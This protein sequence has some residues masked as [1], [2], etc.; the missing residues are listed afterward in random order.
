[1]AYWMITNRHVPSSGGLGNELSDELSYWIASK[2][3]LKN[4]RSWTRL[5]ETSR[6]SAAVQFESRL[7]AVAD[8]FPALA[9]DA[10]HASQKHV[11]FFVH[12]YNVNW[13]DAAGRY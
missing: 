1:M 4:W 9:S 2:G 11:T 8:R 6:Q 3:P 13:M 10:D 7:A 5:K 12:G